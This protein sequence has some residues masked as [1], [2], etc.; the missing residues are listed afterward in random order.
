M[1]AITLLLAVALL[2]FFTVPSMSAD[3]AAKTHR[4]VT[5]GAVT[6]D[7]IVEGH[8][9][10]IVML[11]S[12]GRDSEDYDEVAAGL[13]AAG[14][15]VLRPQPRGILKSTGPMQG[16]TLHDLAADIALV[17]EKLGQG[18]AVIVGHA[19][20]NWVA[21]MTAVDHPQLV[22]GVVLAAAAAKSYPRSL[23]ESVT[24]SADPSLSD[25]ERLKHLRR[26]FFALQSDPHVW[27][28]GWYPAVS[29]MQREASKATK[30]AE[31]WS[32]GDT[33]LL[34]LQ[35]DMDPFRPEDTRN[36]LRDEFGPRVT[37]AVVHGASHAMLPEQPKAVVEAV[38]RWV[39][40]LPR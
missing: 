14:Y 10:T 34:D 33:P 15:R 9:P 39:A 27:L 24:A 26:V 11:P 7:V 2:G 38:T 5:S 23:S 13:A 29:K 37:V 30:Q 6:I 17:I 22:R 3:E 25:E 1:R 21:R 31:W 4:L 18:R 36:Q 20:G 28:K 35:S 40:T 8:G 19:Y 32:A 12:R 16:V